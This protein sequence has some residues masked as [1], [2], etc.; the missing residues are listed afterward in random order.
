MHEEVFDI[1][2]VVKS[3]E[4]ELISMTQDCI[5]SLRKCE[6]TIK[7]NIIIIE[8]HTFRGYEDVNLQLVFI[9][10]NF[11]YNEALNYGFSFC[12]NQHILFC[13]NDLIFHEGFDLAL[14]AGFDAG[15]LSLSPFNWRGVT[16][17]ITTDVEFLEGYR[18]GSR[19]MGW[20]IAVDRKIFD[21]IGKFDDGVEFWYSDHLYA[22]QIKKAGIK[23]ALCI[24]SFVDHLESRT[25]NLCS[26]AESVEKQIGQ[27]PKYEESLIRIMRV[28]NG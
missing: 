6:K 9:K 17:E 26:L 18:I 22:H 10:S 16:G 19:I 20:C 28:K 25:L 24:H 7:F 8:T 13:N 2:L 4:P 15:Y 27:I 23:H 11:N 14:K 12:H 5:N 21:S 1:V 3:S